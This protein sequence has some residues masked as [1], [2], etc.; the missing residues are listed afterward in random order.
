MEIKHGRRII[1]VFLFVAIAALF[2]CTG[3]PK[4]QPKFD[5]I[6]RG[7]RI[8]DGTGNPWYRADVGIRDGRIAAL[9]RL[10]DKEAA[11]TID[12]DDRFVAPGFID[13]MGQST[14]ALLQDSESALSKLYQGITTMLS[15]EGTS[16]APQ[17]DR[18]QPEGL[19][20]GETRYRWRTYAEYFRIM[21]DRGV[22]L[23]V[24]HNVG[25]AQLR[26]LVL[27]DQDLPLSAEDLDRMKGLL[28]EAMRD[29]AVGFSTALIYP[30]GA[31]ASAEEIRALA[32]VA[33][34]HNGIYLTHVRNESAGLLEAIEEAVRVGRETGIPVHIYHL[35]AAGQENWP[36]MREA[37]DMISK[38][39]ADGVD[40]TADIYPYIRNGLL[41]EAFIHPQ[42]YAVGTEEFVQ[43]LGKQEVRDSVRR[44]LEDTSDWENWYRH[45]GK[46]WGNVLIDR[47]GGQTEPECVGRSVQEVAEMR[48]VDV[49]KAFF[50]MIQERGVHV[51]PKSQN[52][53]QKREA[54]LAP[55]VMI[56]TDASPTNPKTAASAHP[57]A[58]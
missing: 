27:G 51:V 14:P 42:R 5:L 30:P 52:E 15:G 35:K 29:G 23:N 22:A 21:E 48:G 28:D 39:R 10:T 7:A 54:L 58:F 19:K 37:L 9:G 4:T 44:E 1:F 32:E 16:A 12:A 36:L 24:I 45:V 31:F 11:G 18:T 55:F 38:A 50:D 49:W 6:I 33:A 41:L 20:I 3:G 43:T 25:A 26:L 56:D 17:N 34:R 47:V 13:M 2:T 8:I 46:D 53:E 57:R 40:V